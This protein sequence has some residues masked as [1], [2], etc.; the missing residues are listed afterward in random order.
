MDDVIGSQYALTPGGAAIQ[1]GGL[2]AYPATDAHDTARAVIAIQTRPA[3]PPRSRLMHTR[4]AIPVPHSMMPLEHGT[5]PDPTGA[6][7]FFVVCPAPP[8]PSLAADPRPWSEGDVLRFLLLPAAAA[9]DA[10]DGRGITHRA[11]R[12]DNIFRAGPGEKVTLGPCWAAPPGSLQPSPFEP[13]YS[14]QCLPAA[15]GEGTAAD[16]VY[17]LGVTILWCVLGGAVPGWADEPA[18]L[19]C[20]LSQGSLAALAGPVRLSPTMADLLR[21]MLAEDPD[22]RPAASLLLDLEQARSRRVATR[23]ASRAQRPLELAGVQIWFPRE[24]AWALGAAPDQGAVLLR[25][26]TI[27]AWLRRVL[28]DSGLAVR[29]DEA[30]ARGDLAGD[31]PKAMHGMVCRAAAALDPLAPLVWRGHAVFPDGIGAALAHAVLTGQT[32]LVAALEEMLT[33]DA[34]AAWLSGRIPRA[35]YTRMQQEVRDWKDWLCTPGVAGGLPRVLYGANLLLPC[36]SPLL[37]G[38][39]VTMVSDLLPALEAFAPDADRKRPPMD[40]QIA[41]FIAARADPTTLG[42]AAR[43]TGFVSPADRLSAMG[44][45]GRLQQRT[46]CEALPRL[47]AW[48]LGKRHGGTGPVAVPGHPQI[49]AGKT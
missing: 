11:I 10:M 24:L 35:D 42:D 38:R 31:G 49:P 19:K 20:K 5:I 45:L 40:A 13:P 4:A 26:G 16:D 21:G 28:G 34:T 15:R 43:L 8:G 1:V 46:A 32:A 30:V 23:P 22:H 27:S 18:L 12:P 37:N 2:T 36:L 9:L 17:A 14:A 39:M 6:A 41:A 29:V 33:Q 25:N 3:L 48:L 44:A 47:A 7:A